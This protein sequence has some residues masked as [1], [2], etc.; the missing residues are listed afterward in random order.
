MLIRLLKNLLYKILIT[1]SKLMVDLFKLFIITSCFSVI[2]FNFMYHHKDF[3][4]L[5]FPKFY[6]GSVIFV[7]IF[8]FSYASLKSCKVF[9]KDRIEQTA[10]TKIKIKSGL[11]LFYYS[12]LFFFFFAFIDELKPFCFLFTSLILFVFFLRT[13]FFDPVFLFFGFKFYKIEIDNKIK[14][15]LITK[16]KIKEFSGIETIKVRSFTDYVFIEI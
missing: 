4:F 13:Y 11:Y 12:L 1:F 7:Y 8:I 14:I 10:I 2:V 6:Q 16:R 5:F 3:S 9:G 15:N